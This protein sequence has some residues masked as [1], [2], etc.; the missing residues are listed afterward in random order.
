VFRDAYITGIFKARY[1]LID[2]QF[3]DGLYILVLRNKSTRREHAQLGN[4]KV[5]KKVKS[6]HPS[7]LFQTPHFSNPHAVHVRASKMT[8][9]D[10][11]V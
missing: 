8:G 4:R 6:V 7:T 3:I 2:M 9:T 5:S 1:L 11:K 10:S